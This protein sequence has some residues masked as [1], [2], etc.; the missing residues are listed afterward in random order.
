[1]LTFSRCHAQNLESSQKTSRAKQRYWTQWKKDILSVKWAI[2]HRNVRAYGSASAVLVLS[3]KYV[4]TRYIL[5]VK[6]FLGSALSTEADPKFYTRLAFLVQFF[7]LH[8]RSTTSSWSVC[9]LKSPNMQNRKKSILRYGR[10]IVAD[11]CWKC[12][13]RWRRKCETTTSQILYYNSKH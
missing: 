5:K 1:M 2:G 10:T 6:Y 11:L 12:V 9:I 4:C 8:K 7:S 13:P 3:R